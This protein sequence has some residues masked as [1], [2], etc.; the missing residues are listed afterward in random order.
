MLVEVDPASGPGAQWTPTQ[1]LFSLQP[2]PNRFSRLDIPFVR[3][4]EVMGE[5]RLQ[6]SGRLLAGLDVILLDE[7][8]AEVYRTTTFTDGVFYFMGVRPGRYRAVVAPEGLVQQGLGAEAS[9]LD[10]RTTS[11]GILEDLILWIGPEELMN[12]AGR[13][14]RGS[15]SGPGVEPGRTTGSG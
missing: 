11:D 14:R 12:P 10:V 2:D 9:I 4:V 1:T 15:E 13:N 3:T 5:V 8:G 6:P 7:S